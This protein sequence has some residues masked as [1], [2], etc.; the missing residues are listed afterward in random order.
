LRE[1]EANSQ[2][3]LTKA[4]VDPDRFHRFCSR[5]TTFQTRS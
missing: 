5:F 2:F 1:I 4:H 3:Y